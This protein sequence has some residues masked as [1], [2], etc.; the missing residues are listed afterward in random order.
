MSV[1]LQKQ[2]GSLAYDPGFGYLGNARVSVSNYVFQS[3]GRG[4]H[5]HSRE[6][7][8][9]L[10]KGDISDHYLTSIRLTK[11][12]KQRD[13]TFQKVDSNGIYRTFS[14][15]VTSSVV[16]LPKSLFNKI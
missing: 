1:R 6:L 10:L 14:V 3:K 12:L 4:G 15:P 9:V 13:L 2:K 8:E 16:P 7:A 11:F 5:P